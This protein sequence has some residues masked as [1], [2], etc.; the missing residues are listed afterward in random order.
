MNSCR[1]KWR[2]PVSC[3]VVRTQASTAAP[4]PPNS[5]SWAWRNWKRAQSS[6]TASVWRA[7]PSETNVTRASSGSEPS[8]MLEPTQPA[9]GPLRKD[10]P[11]L[12]Q[13]RSEEVAWHKEETRHRPIGGAVFQEGIIGCGAIVDGFNLLV[14]CRVRNRTAKSS[15]LTFELVCGRAFGATEVQNRSIGL[16]WAQLVE[17]ASGAIEVMGCPLLSDSARNLAGALVAH[18]ST[19]VHLQVK[20]RRAPV[21]VGFRRSAP[22]ARQG[23]P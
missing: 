21:D 23:A 17:G 10:A 16:G 12:G 5:G 4:H 2:E 19:G 1:V 22:C 15:S 8:R 13:S 18:C 11:V 7:L 6:R 20:Q 9:V 14:V 3:M